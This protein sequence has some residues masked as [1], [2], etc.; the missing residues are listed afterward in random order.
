MV[1][2]EHCRDQ[3]LSQDLNLRPTDP[4]TATL[5]TKPPSTA[6]TSYLD[7]PIMVVQHAIFMIEPNWHSA[8]AMP[9][10]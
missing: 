5:T 1:E 3:L 8:K 2:Y 6:T 7:Q 10:S 9:P 4:E